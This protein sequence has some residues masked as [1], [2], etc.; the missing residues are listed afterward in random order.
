MGLGRGTP[1]SDNCNVMRLHAIRQFTP[2]PSISC[3]RIEQQ[4]RLAVLRCFRLCCPQSC[5]WQHEREIWFSTAALLWDRLL[6]A[7]AGGKRSQHNMRPEEMVAMLLVVSKYLGA[8]VEAATHKSIIASVCNHLGLR[9]SR[10]QVL[11]WERVLCMLCLEVL[12][13]P[14]GTQFAFAIWADACKRTGPALCLQDMQR[15]PGTCAIQM[16]DQSPRKGSWP[17]QA[18][19]L[20]GA[21]AC[22][23]P[24]LAYHCNGSVS[25]ACDLALAALALSA[26]GFGCV[27][28]E[29]I[30]FMHHV[31]QRFGRGSWIGLVHSWAG[32]LAVAVPA[33]LQPPRLPCGLDTHPKWCKGAFMVSRTITVQ[34]FTTGQS[35]L[36]GVKRVETRGFRLQPGWW[37][38]HVGAR[39][40]PEAVA[41]VARAK[42][43]RNVDEGAPK[44]AILG[45]FLVVGT[46]PS[47]IIPDC[48]ALQAFGRFSSIIGQTITFATPFPCRGRLG[49]WKV[50]PAL[51]SQMDAAMA[52]GTHRH[53]NLEDLAEVMRNSTAGAKAMTSN[54]ACKTAYLPKSCLSSITQRCDTTCQPYASRKYKRLTSVAK[55]NLNL[56]AVRNVRNPKC[57]GHLGLEPVLPSPRKREQELQPMKKRCGGL[58]DGKYEMPRS[59]RSP[60]PCNIMAP[61]EFTPLDRHDRGTDDMLTHR[62]PCNP[63]LE[64]ES[65]IEAAEE[66]F[67]TGRMPAGKRRKPEHQVLT[68]ADLDLLMTDEDTFHTGILLFSGCLLM[69]R[70]FWREKK[71][72]RRTFDVSEHIRRSNSKIP[73][74]EVPEETDLIALGMGGRERVL[75]QLCCFF[76]ARIACTVFEKTRPHK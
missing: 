45:R 71:V 30:A 21:L 56:H 9:I 66:D 51:M 6:E 32:H 25:A 68:G 33:W 31:G 42:G 61:V 50:T 2:E 3:G 40:T 15:W 73:P 4:S 46:L 57:I 60:V 69:H 27:P 48:W 64:G 75:R 12:V 70:A 74:P 52:H 17:H 18:C 34:G 58:I 14:D 22:W 63:K 67:C 20:I 7:R 76:F 43:I 24:D 62:S 19:V 1:L 39:D 16:L 55:K 38:L 59:A 49:P 72:R 36:L 65:I 29:M 44:S 13:P 26:D 28:L 23:R 53:V 35:M 47:S 11:Q 5:Q 37:N 41:R 54:T 10:K 8:K